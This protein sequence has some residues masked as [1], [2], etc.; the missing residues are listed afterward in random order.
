MSRPKTPLDIYYIV[1]GNTEA[2]PQKKTSA[3]DILI[4][5]AKD[6]LIP[7]WFIKDAY[8]SIEA[9]S[10]QSIEKLIKP[11][12]SGEEL[13]PYKNALGNEWVIYDPNSISPVQ[14]YVRYPKKNSSDLLIEAGS[15]NKYVY[16]EFCAELVNYCRSHCPAKKIQINSMKVNSMK[17]GGGAKKVSAYI[18]LK[19]TETEVFS[20]NSPNGLV[21]TEPLDR[22]NW[23]DHMLKE[24]ISSLKEGAS[25]NKET[26]KDFSFG[27]GAD[28][29]KFIHADLNF[30]REYKF[31]INIEC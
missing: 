5:G 21:W 13:E 12:R 24:S 25:L 2:G 19:N 11:I 30:A 31:T 4:R 28:I 16:D 23:L 7:F 18:E 29:L 22:Y 3:K 1:D 14:F 27:T 20:I 9:V 26:V 17:T 15:F 10:N 6:A 8:E